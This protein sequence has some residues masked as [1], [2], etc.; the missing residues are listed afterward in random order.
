MSAQDPRI[1]SP[2]QKMWD[3]ILVEAV[4]DRTVR[5][6]LSKAY[7]GFLLATRPLAS[8]L[9]ISGRVLLLRIFMVPHTIS[10]L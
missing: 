9:N 4:D 2:K 1:Q 6:T 3:G 8:F 10:V 7:A 5:F